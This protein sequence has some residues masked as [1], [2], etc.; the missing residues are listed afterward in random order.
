VARRFTVVRADW[1]WVA[2]ITHVRTWT[3]WLSL[4][5]VLDTP[6]TKLAVGRRCREA[7]WDLSASPRP[8]PGNH[9]GPVIIPQY[10][11]T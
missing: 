1:L 4:A 5:V 2:D 8:A 7:A 11:M 6:V 9:G 3:D 10:A